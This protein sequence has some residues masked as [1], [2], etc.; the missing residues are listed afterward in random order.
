MT[1]IKATDT[2]VMRVSEGNASTALD[3]A[4]T[5]PITN[6]L[7]R[8]RSGKNVRKQRSSNVRL[9]AIVVVGSLFLACVTT[10]PLRSAAA[11][12]QKST[13]RTQRAS[14]SP[15]TIPA[16]PTTVATPTTTVPIG[17]PVLAFA[18]LTSCPNEEAAISR[19]P[20][21]TRV[22]QLVAIGAD[23]RGLMAAQ[24]LV[25]EQHIGGLLVRSAP[26][27]ASRISADLAALRN[28]E[29]AL[30]T[31]FSVDE[32]GGR[33]QVL[34]SIV[35]SFPSAR[36][37]AASS[38]SKVAKLV[39]EHHKKVRALGFDMILGPVLDVTSSNVGVIGDRS[40]GGDPMLVGV[41][42]SA[43]AAGVRD[44]GMTPVIKHFPG[45]G[46]GVGDTHV[47]RVSTPSIDALRLSDEIPFRMAMAD[48]PTAV[49]IGH[50]EVP[51][52]TG[53]TP[54]TLS[55]AA[56]S[57]ELRTVLGFDGLVVTDSLSMGAV[58]SRWNAP[59]AAVEAIAAGA[60][61]ALF[62]TISERDAIGVI[63]ALEYAVS[64]GRIA[65]SQLNRSVVRIV[66]SKNLDP[67]AIDP[68]VL[69]QQIASA[70]LAYRSSR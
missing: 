30:P 66:R 54:S 67:C 26:A 61:V 70:E 16:T 33:V 32:E 47:G 22:A 13:V 7:A 56:I 57:F 41:L 17:K 11:T 51:G 48:G 46:G 31:S 45:H 62:V 34:R 58:T 18:P 42:G 27:S 29:G 35:G 10:S 38:P 44:A 69:E 63:D 43:Y 50:L 25:G 49:M 37:L 24:R 6:L 59:S 15:T 28:L 21:R 9:T 36:K 23:G 5:T 40:F 1:D 53:E 19:W 55:L 14:T 39:S 8:R 52:L 12:K 65:E 2:E 20:L 3:V 4:D 64:V 68:A 60:D